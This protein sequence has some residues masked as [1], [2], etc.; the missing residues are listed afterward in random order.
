MHAHHGHHKG[1]G[2]GKHH[3]SNH[4]E[5]HSN[6]GGHKGK[7]HGHWMHH[8]WHHPGMVGMHMDSNGNDHDMS[9][10]HGICP[11]QVAGAVGIFIAFMIG[12]AW[13]VCERNRRRR[14]AEENGGY[15]PRQGDYHTGIL[16]CLT[17][18]RVCCPSTFLT[19][20]LAAFNRAEADNREC[21]PCDVLWALKTPITQYHTRQTIRSTH[22]LEEAPVTD[23]L[24]AVCC[25]PCVV[26][27]DTLEL[28][29]RAAMQPP[30]FHQA[31]TVSIPMEPA[32]GAPTMVPPPPP[33]P[34]KEDLP[35]PTKGEYA[36]VPAEAQV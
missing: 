30:L 7:H 3:D 4:G 20:F 34:M 31:V 24:G 26:A 22:D 35:V 10:F 12:V 16:S 5:H 6:H 32:M 18:P 2:K 23:C 9:K 33:P 27:Q 15:K 14:I 19:P 36:Q 8:G 11:F 13:A 25:M 28:E 21:H 1:K 29:H 17:V